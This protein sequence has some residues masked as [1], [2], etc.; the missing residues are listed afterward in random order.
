MLSS[1]GAINYLWQPGNLSGSSVVVNPTATTA[2]VVTGTDNNGCTG[3]DTVLVTVNQ[4]PT[5]FS[6]ASQNVFCQGNSTTLFASGA[7]SYIWQPGNLTGSV[8][9]VTPAVSTTYTVTVTTGSC[10]DTSTTLI[11]EIGRAHV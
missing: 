10:G 11:V 7:S 1:S 5:V 3:V 9:S 6:S 2:F 8:V 4:S